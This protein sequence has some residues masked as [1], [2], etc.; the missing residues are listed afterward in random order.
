MK[1]VVELNSVVPLLF[2]LFILQVHA[3]ICKNANNKCAWCHTC[4][5]VNNKWAWCHTCRNV[6]N[7]WAWCHT[8]KNANNKCAWCHTCK[9]ANNKC[10]WYHTCKNANNKCAWYVRHKILNIQLSCIILWD[11]MVLIKALSMCYFYVS[12][13]THMKGVGFL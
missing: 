5:N 12:T 4:R 6:N 2:V 1:Q 11:K 9:N 13:H 7:K 3:S 10:A 8:C